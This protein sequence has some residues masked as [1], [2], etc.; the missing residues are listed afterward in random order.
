[1]ADARDSKSLE[2]NFMWVRLPPPAPQAQGLGVQPCSGRFLLVNFASWQL[3]FCDKTIRSRTHWVRRGTR[4]IV[5]IFWVGLPPPAP[6]KK[7]RFCLGNTSGVPSAVALVFSLSRQSQMFEIQTFGA[8]LNLVAKF[9]APCGSSFI[10]F[11]LI[12]S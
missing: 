11:L 9:P 4:K 6:E 3:F 5:Q 10:F 12:F 1:M 8:P 2:G 7:R